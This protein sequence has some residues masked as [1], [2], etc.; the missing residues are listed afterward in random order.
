M[1]FV[2]LV[3]GGKDSIYSLMEAIAQGHELVCAANLSPAPAAACRRRH[4]IPRALYPR[5]P[6]NQERT[7]LSVGSLVF[8]SFAFVS[9]H[10]RAASIPPTQR[11]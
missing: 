7:S 3:S 11:H 1:K 4:R 5:P 8:F 6:R 2:A 10:A 9:V